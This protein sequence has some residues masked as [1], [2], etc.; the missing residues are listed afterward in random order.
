MEAITHALED[1]KN[2]SVEP[3]GVYEGPVCIIY[4]EKSP[5]KISSREEFLKKHFPRSQFVP[6]ENASHS[7]HSECPSEFTEAL[8]NFILEE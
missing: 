4:G 2:L 3:T 5:F 8:V 1:P 6:V 7:V